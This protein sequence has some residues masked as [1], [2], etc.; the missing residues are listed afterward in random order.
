MASNDP[1]IA[2]ASS[3]A[4]RGGKS[5]RTFEK[6][7]SDWLATSITTAKAL[8]AG[9]EC[10]PFPYVKGVFGTAVIVLETIEKVK[11]NRD[12]LKELCENIMD[13]IGIIQDQLSTHG[14]TA[15]AKFKGLC[16]DL[17]SVL[18]NVLAAVE[19]L[20][21]EP[22]SLRERFKEAIKLSSTAD[23][24][25]GYRARLQELRSNFL[26]FNIP[27]HSGTGSQTRQLMAAIDTNL[28][29]HKALTAGIPGVKTQIKRKPLAKECPVS[30]PIFKGRR[31][32][33]DS[34]SAYFS[35]EQGA[36]HVSLLHGLGG[37]GKT[38]I[39]LK[40]VEESA[41]VSRFSAVFFIDA[42]TQD[43]M[44]KDLADIA[45]AND[46]GQ[47]FEDALRWFAHTREEWLLLFNN[48]DDTGIDLK[49]YF[50]KCTHGNILITSRNPALRVH[51]QVNAHEISG[52]KSDD[53][54]D[55]LLSSAAESPSSAD[56]R[57]IAAEIVKELHYLA[58]AIVQ[59]GAFI[60][61]SEALDRY[62]ELYRENRAMLLTEHP[63]QS[64]DDY[65]ETV[66]TTWEISF[67]RL[68]PTAA[69]L[70]QLSSFIHHD[71]IWEE[72]LLRAASYIYYTGE[73]SKEELRAPL[74]FLGQFFVVWR[75]LEQSEVYNHSQRAARILSHP[76]R[77]A[78]SL[79]LDPSD[80]AWMLI[81]MSINWGTDQADYAF[82]RSLI[83]HLDVLLHTKPATIELKDFCLH[84]AEVYLDATK[85]REAAALQQAGLAKRKALLGNNHIETLTAMEHLANTY[86][87]LGKLN[88]AEALHT[89]VLKSRRRICGPDHPLTLTAMANLSSTYC[90]LDKLEASRV[91]GLAAMKKMPAML[92]D[93]HPDTLS[94][95]MILAKTYKGLHDFS[96]AEQILVTVLNKQNGKLGTDHPDTIATQGMLAST[97]LD[98]DRVE[99]AEELYEVVLEKTIRIMGND[100]PAA[101]SARNDLG[102][103]YWKLCAHTKSFSIAHEV[104]EQRTRILGA[105]HPDT[106]TTMANLAEMHWELGHMR[107]AEKIGKI[108]TRRMAQVLGADHPDSLRAGETLSSTRR[109]LQL[110]NEAEGLSEAELA[111]KKQDWDDDALGRLGAAFWQLGRMKEATEIAEVVLQRTLRSRG[112]DHQ[113]TQLAI[114]NLAS[115]YRAHRKVHEATAMD[116]V[117][118]FMARITV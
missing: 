52:M 109:Q 111:R 87:H 115:A 59:A 71:D 30:S 20:Q 62:L 106:L 76:I 118:D 75:Y 67:N 84:Y 101:V 98:S 96:R 66:Y 38:Q 40:F 35:G 55:L 114:G 116:S 69:R 92:G 17:Q 50:P 36:P 82:R 1:S 27:L 47:S 29:L 41:A 105:D 32:I 65:A 14:D 11:K 51:A 42:S 107:D 70:L 86:I 19:E 5:L 28:Q 16:R 63:S 8:T 7:N 104:L 68:S 49:A 34:L 99:K 46:V 83:P 9:A 77:Q 43:T 60:S 39:A 48:A 100:H 88:E 79:I 15:A 6:S 54:I 12:D 61:K 18:Q 95:M 37:S 31:D 58:L 57:R 117:A 45:G 90:D 103:C 44:Q 108:V 113:D 94:T 78:E 93:D 80:G 74:E 33:L 56:N 23:Q 102:A 112:K 3:S 72:I 2:P 81:A 53:A 4:P 26:V 91:L 22:R 97:Y 89:A 25:S 73:P 64:Q 10:I 21:V 85:W 24:I 110:W 13:V